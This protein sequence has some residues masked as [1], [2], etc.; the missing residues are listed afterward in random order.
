MR[1]TKNVKSDRTL[2]QK[3]V[4]KNVNVNIHTLEFGNTGVRNRIDRTF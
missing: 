4:I 3:T 1:R 2:W